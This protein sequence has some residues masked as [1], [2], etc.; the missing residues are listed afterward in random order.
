MGIGFKFLKAF[1]GDSI[2]ISTDKNNIL[3]DGGTKRSFYIYLKKEIDYLRKLDKKLDL[4][5]LTHID[6]DHIDGIIEMLKYEKK[7]IEEGQIISPIF[8]EIWFNAFEKEI[9]S[10]DFSNETSYVGYKSFREI[11]NSFHNINYNDYLSIDN[12]IEYFINSEIK[13]TLLSPN[14]KKLN[15][16]HHK[17]QEKIEDDF[18]T[19]YSKDIDK[20]IE[21]LITLPFKKDKSEHNGASIAFIL[22]YQTKKYLFLA[23]AHIDLIE[24]SLKELGYT[25][26]NPL[27]VEFIKLSHHGSKKNIN[28][29]FLD[30]VRSN[31]F[32]I[33][34]NGASHGHPDKEALSRVILNKNRDFNEKLYFICNYETI[35]EH[36]GFSDAE[37]K[38]YN[39]ELIY[40]SELVEGDNNEK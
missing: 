23:D 32:I 11:L 31:K 18:Y 28:Q 24:K 39:F 21:E 7:L 9:F 17:Y 15:R 14:D 34:T 1:N 8:K 13:I 36:H 26:K 33:L 12:Q 3:I 16:L 22:E 4:V 5:V 35:L 27:K 2:L 25:Q 20:S 29:G 19:S 30:L 40:K 38:K 10:D 6:S 37:K